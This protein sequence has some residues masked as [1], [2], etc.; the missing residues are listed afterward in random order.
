MWSCVKETDLFSPFN[1]Q[2]PV[3]LVNQSLIH[4]YFPPIAQHS[5]KESS[6]IQ[7]NNQ[8]HQCPL[9]FAMLHRISLFSFYLIYSILNL[10]LTYESH[11]SDLN[12]PFLHLTSD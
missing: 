3:H 5:I 4:L 8:T 7:Q 6:F 1:Y 10:K 9:L 11:L 12:P 2:N